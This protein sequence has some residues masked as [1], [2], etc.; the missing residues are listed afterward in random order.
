MSD[1]V[2]CNNGKHL[3][4][5]LWEQEPHGKQASKIELD[6]SGSGNE[7]NIHGY[8]LNE[9]I[10]NIGVGRWSQR[11]QKHSPAIYRKIQLQ[12]I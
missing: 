11:E 5:S 7:L 9:Y 6:D 3:I 10:L 2:D 4:S 12:S 1:S 8:V